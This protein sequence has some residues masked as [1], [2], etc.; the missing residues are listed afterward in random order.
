M[1][2]LAHI[3]R[4]DK[5]A[6]NNAPKGGYAEQRDDIRVPVS[7][8][9]TRRCLRCCADLDCCMGSACVCVLLG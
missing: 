9:M 6:P 4:K 5:N 7:R 8:D 2:P 1:E 3:T